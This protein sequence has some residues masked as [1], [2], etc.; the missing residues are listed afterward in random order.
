MEQHTGSVDS[1]RLN[2]LRYR[3]FRLAFCGTPE[4]QVR[5]GEVMQ[6][7]LAGQAMT[8]D[9]LD[10]ALDRLIANIDYVIEA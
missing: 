6:A 10:A 2:A 3:S 9:L 7:V 1:N 4:Q 5:A 8:P